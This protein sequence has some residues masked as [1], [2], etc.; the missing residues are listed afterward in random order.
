MHVEAHRRR[1]ERQIRRGVVEHRREAARDQEELPRLIETQLVTA[2]LKQRERRNHGHEDTR[3]QDRDLDDRLVVEAVRLSGRLGRREHADQREH[4]HHSLAVRRRQEDRADHPEQERDVEP[5][6]DVQRDLLGRVA[7]D[8]P[9]LLLRVRAAVHDVEQR[10]ASYERRREIIREHETYQKGWLYFI[11]TDSR[12]PQHVRE[13]MSSWGLAADEFSDNGHWPHQIYVREARRMIGSYVMTENEL[14]KRRPTP[15]SVGMGSYSIDS[16][17]VQRY[18]T[19]EGTVQNEGDIGVSTYGPYEIAYGSLTPKRSQCKN[20]L[21]PVCV[22]SSHIAFGSI[23]MEPVFMILGQSAATAA[24]LAIE[25]NQPVQ[26]VAYEQLRQ[27]LIADGQILQ[28]DGPSGA[29]VSAKKFSGV[30]I[31]DTQAERSGNWLG[32]AANQPFVGYGYQHDSNRMDGNSKAVFSANLETGRYAVQIG[33]PRNANRSTKTPVTVFYDAGSKTVL[34]DQTKKPT[35]DGLF[36]PIGTY[37]F[38]DQQPARVTITNS[39]TDGYVVI[40]AVRFVP[41]E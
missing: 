27:R 22:S 12:I 30:V 28:F 38:T 15:N 21:V 37:E 33:Y 6:L 20:L 25:A 8:V 24:V 19:P 10:E 2:R 11:T 39:D 32:S 13:E 26:D 3:E 35:I 9:G 17:N 41:V 1:E 7:R 40:D 36:Q 18:I 23:R 5:A 34:L 29:G 16:H 14:R 4:Q 31:D